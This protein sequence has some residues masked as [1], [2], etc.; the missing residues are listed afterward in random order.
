LQRVIERRA[1]EA[2]Q[3]VERLPMY[4]S[5]LLSLL[6]DDA[7][8]AAD[9]A[10]LVGQDPSLVGLTLK[11]IN[12]AY[13]GLRSRVNDLHHAVLLL[14]F[15][16]VYQLALAEALRGMMPDRP[17]FAQLRIHS[18]VVSILGQELSLLTDVKPVLMGTIGLLH[19]IGKSVV[20]LLR[21]KN[22][23][24]EGF[25]DR[26]DPC[27]LGSLLLQ[28]W[29][30]PEIICDTVACQRYPESS[31]PDEILPESRKTVSVL[32]AAH[33]AHDWLCGSP[34]EDL[35]VLFLRS[36]LAF[37]S[38][39]ATSVEDLVKN[40]LVPLLRRR[41]GSFPEEVRPFFAGITGETLRSKN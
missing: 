25:M 32:Y 19:D 17:E 28:R 41:A 40:R 22:P 35:P 23:G 9:V 31:P 7:I 36:H 27:R 14:G 8:S 11:S 10:R 18:L 26:L 15:H 12:S 34:E 2:L 5:R 1:E 39:E 30:I 38:L 3:R 33:L 4:A 16:Q 37:C 21:R 20:L 29:N 24:I 13:F 6:R